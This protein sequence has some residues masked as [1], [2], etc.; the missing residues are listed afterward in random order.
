[1]FRPRIHTYCNCSAHIGPVPMRYGGRRPWGRQLAHI[2][3]CP[4]S[5][6][7]QVYI[8]RRRRQ[9][10]GWKHVYIRVA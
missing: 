4:F 2:M 9:R 5:G 6:I 7:Q 8:Y 10:Y 1:M 3:Y